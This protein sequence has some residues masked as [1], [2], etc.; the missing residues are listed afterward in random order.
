MS[1]LS[2]P[3][4]GQ[5]YKDP[6]TDQAFRIVALDEEGDSIE[7]QYLNGDISGL[8]FNA[9]NDGG[10]DSIEAPE[11]WAAPFDDVENDDLGYSDPDVHSPDLRELTLEDIL[12]EEDHL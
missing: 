1:N 3:Y 6:A 9:W 7:L 4:L 12:N 8:D 5:W 2:E 10:F 11:D